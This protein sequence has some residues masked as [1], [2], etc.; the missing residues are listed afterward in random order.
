MCFL[1]RHLCSVCGENDRA[2]W[3]FWLINNFPDHHLQVYV[4]LLRSSSRKTRWWGWPV[5][6]YL[7]SSVLLSNFRAISGP[8][9]QSPAVEARPA[10]RF[11]IRLYDMR[12]GRE[13]GHFAPVLAVTPEHSKKD[14]LAI[15]Y[16]KHIRF[17]LM[18]DKN[19]CHFKMLHRLKNKYP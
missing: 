7:K 8:N 18:P 12:F 3:C 14:A 15:I 19:H 16:P 10:A 6:I 9:S 4:V 11:H 17:P 1:Q 13:C 2:A 5:M